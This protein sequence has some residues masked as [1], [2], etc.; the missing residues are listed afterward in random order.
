MAHDALLNMVCNV[1][2][3]LAFL[4][5]IKKQL[6]NISTPIHLSGTNLDEAFSFCSLFDGFIQ[7]LECK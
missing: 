6:K 7:Y 1:A 3:V 5:L 4:K 2:Y